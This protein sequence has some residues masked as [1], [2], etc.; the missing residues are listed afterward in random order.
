MLTNQQVSKSVNQRFR[1]SGNHMKRL[2][3]QIAMLV[4]VGTMTAQVPATPPPPPAQATPAPQ[5]TPAMP[6][7]PAIPA[8][9]PKPR[10]RVYR[11]APVV[12]SSSGSYLG[13]DVRDVT[14][15]RARELKLKNDQGVE[16]TM[17]DQDGPA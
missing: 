4:L 16:I 15:N 5:A 17:V 6:A 1:N 13:V 9:A 8:P 12:A 2:I 10:V 3:V 7:T 11:T 14:P